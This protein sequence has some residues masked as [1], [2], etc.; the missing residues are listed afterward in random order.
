MKKLSNILLILLIIVFIVISLTTK[1]NSMNIDDLAYALAIG[2]DSGENN[3]FNISFQFSKPESDSNS[4]SSSASSFIYSVECSSINS[5]INLMNSYVS[6]E[7]NLAHCK[8][9]IF[10]EEVAVRGISEEIYT[11][12]NDIQLRPDTAIIVSKSKAKEYIENSKPDLESSISEYYEITPESS[13]YTGFTDYMTIGK[14]YN[15]LCSNSSETYAILGGVNTGKNTNSNTNEDN[16]ENDTSAKANETPF[17]DKPAS[18]NLGIAVFKNDKLV[19]ELDASEAVSHLIVTNKF[20]S[21][22]I[23]VP[24]PMNSDS[25]LDLYLY[26]PKKTKIKVDIVNGSPFVTV[27]CNLRAR[28]LSINRI[29][30]SSNSSEM[31]DNLSDTCSSYLESKI[32]DY[33]YTTSKKYNSDIAGIGRYALKNFSNNNKWND[34]DWL[35]NYKNSFFSVNVNVNVKSGMILTEN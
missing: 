2:I 21:T 13:S 29:S 11:L 24:D 27:K 10:S 31:L 6:K 4:Q 23:S 34:F 35:N 9:I 8:A 16:S 1:R 25:N 18:E 26:G 7:I 30:D 28:V 14:F 3:T 15:N 20:K 5:G 12:I 17:Q 33:L 22:V 19:G 32:S